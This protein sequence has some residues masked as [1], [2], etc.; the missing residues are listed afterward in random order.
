MQL[1]LIRTTVRILERVECVE[2]VKFEGLPEGMQI[3]LDDLLIIGTQKPEPEE[4]PA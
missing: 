4:E 2:V 3:V 1:Y